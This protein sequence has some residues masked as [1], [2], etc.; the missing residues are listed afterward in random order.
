MKFSTVV[1]PIVLVGASAIVVP[2][3]YVPAEAA[4]S[5]VFNTSFDCPEWNQVGGGDPC[6]AGDGIGRSGDWTT[7]SGKGDQ[8]TSGANNPLGSGRGFR[9][10]RGDGQNNQGGGVS[11]S[12][13][14]SSQLWVRWYARFSQGFAWQNGSPQYT[15]DLY[16]HPGEQGALIAG[17]SNGLFYLHT[18]AGSRNLTSSRSWSAINSG[19]TGDGRFHSYEMYIKLDPSGSNGAT[20]MWVDGILVGEYSGLNF[21]RGSVNSFTLGE[22]QNSVINGDHYTDY[23]DIAISQTGYIGPIGGAV[24]ITAPAAPSQVRIVR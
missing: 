11:I 17:F 16:F 4:P 8:V 7:S 12:F 2:G 10:W 14:S 1:I 23:D 9:H 15:K 6:A 19:A 13:P 18:T 24:P 20:K 22:N 3:G 5:L 21:G